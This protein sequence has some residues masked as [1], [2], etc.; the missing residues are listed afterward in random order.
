MKEYKIN[1]QQLEAL[2]RYLASKPFVE[3]QQLI[4]MLQALPELAEKKD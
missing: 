2:V 3:V 4:Q 1:H